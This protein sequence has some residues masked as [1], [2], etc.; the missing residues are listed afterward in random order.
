V[1]SGGTKYNSRSCAR[2][3]KMTARNVRRSPRDSVMTLRGLLW[4]HALEASNC[5]D[6]SW[7]W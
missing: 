2:A 3:G 6:G 7:H 1:P 5:C 4:K